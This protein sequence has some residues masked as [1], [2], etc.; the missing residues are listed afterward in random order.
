MIRFSFG[1]GNVQTSE[2]THLAY[3]VDN[4]TLTVYV[5]GEQKFSG[6]NFPDIFTGTDSVFSL[7]VNWRDAPFKGQ[8]DELQVYEGA[9][10]PAQVAELVNR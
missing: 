6:S 3:S 1:E 8:L 5:N 9:L 7:G 2:W 10:S 4:G